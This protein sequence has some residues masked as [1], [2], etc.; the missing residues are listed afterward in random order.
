[1]NYVEVNKNILVKLNIL[2]A[3]KTRV[4]NIFWNKQFIRCTENRAFKTKVYY[5]KNVLQYLH[6]KLGRHYVKIIDEN[7]W[8]NF[9]YNFIRQKKCLF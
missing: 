6:K 1:M 7:F 5:N 8:F 2:K 4:S 9:I 3:T